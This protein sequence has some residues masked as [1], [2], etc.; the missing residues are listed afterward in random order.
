LEA[1]H[2]KHPGNEVRVFIIDVNEDKS[3]GG[4]WAAGH[5]LTFPV[6][7]DTDGKVSASFA[8]EGLLPELPRDQIPIGSNLLIDPDG[9]IQFYSLLDTKNFDSKL[10][11]LRAKLYALIAAESPK[12]STDGAQVVTKAISLNK[13]ESVTLK[14]GGDA[15]TTIVITVK[16]GFHV[17]ADGGTE[18]T[19]IPLRID[20]APNQYVTIDEL[21]YP[22]SEP[23][24]FVGSDS[25]WRVYS[26]DVATT[27][28]LSVSSGAG[29]W[30]GA[31]E[32]QI[33]FQSCNDRTCFPPDSI[34]L[35]I[36]IRIGE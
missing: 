21:T 13:P 20:L 28:N 14:K 18:K 35:S 31:L 32:G 7:L 5:G 6:L 34:P 12:L 16:D 26:G 17:L 1:L 4:P 30:Q 33:V 29:S 8:P 15:V 19:L 27:L 23:F 25:P 36:P 9:K 22:E 11:A 10:V 2:R 3:V 24:D